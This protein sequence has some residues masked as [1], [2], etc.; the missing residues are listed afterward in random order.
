MR[1]KFL[2]AIFAR[3]AVRSNGLIASVFI[4]DNTLAAK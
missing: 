1:F 4:A 3:S 2:R